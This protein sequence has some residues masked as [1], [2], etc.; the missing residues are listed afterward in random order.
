MDQINSAAN[1][2]DTATFL[3]YYPKSRQFFIK[4]DNS[5]YDYKDI[6]IYKYTDTLTHTL[7][8]GLHLYHMIIS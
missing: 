5:L 1:V 2:I 4:V 6:H 8:V 3:Q 7:D